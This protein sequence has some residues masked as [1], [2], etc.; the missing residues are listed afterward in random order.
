MEDV[1]EEPIGIKVNEEAESALDK[2]LEQMAPWQDAIKDAMTLDQMLTGLTP[3]TE[4]WPGAFYQSPK[5]KHIK[6]VGAFMTALRESETATVLDIQE[7]LLCF[8]VCVPD[9]DSGQMRRVTPEE[10]EERFHP[11]ELQPIIDK[12]LE[13]D[14][15]KRAPEGN[16]AAPTIGA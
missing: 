11:D 15:F 13:R 2:L 4:V 1:L 16:A 3:I 8:L 5:I 14:G 10:I 7:G 9:A 12:L 6:T